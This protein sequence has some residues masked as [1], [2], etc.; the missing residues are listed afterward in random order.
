M[1]WTTD[2]LPSSRSHHPLCTIRS[3]LERRRKGAPT[4]E[5]RS[6]QIRSGT[7]RALCCCWGS[8]WPVDG[9][10]KS[11]PHGATSN[12]TPRKSA[13]GRTPAFSVE[14]VSGRVRRNTGVGCCSLILSRCSQP[15]CSRTATLIYIGGI[16]R[17]SQMGRRR[18]AKTLPS[19]FDSRPRLRRISL[20]RHA[21]ENTG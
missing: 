13:I 5:Q 19:G 21:P 15:C 17:G 8:V 11:L 20:T 7:T 2:R 18:S 9:S 6:F 4:H 3:R 16:R 14:T 10:G 12:E 1:H